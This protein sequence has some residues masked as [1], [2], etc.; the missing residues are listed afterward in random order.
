MNTFGIELDFLQVGDGERSGDAIAQR[1]GNPLTGYDV[2]I[3]DGGNKASGEELV[4]H[5]TGIYRTGTVQHVVNTHRCRSCLCQQVG[6]G[7]EGEDAEGLVRIGGVGRNACAVRGSVFNAPLEHITG[8]DHDAPVV[9]A[10]IVEVVGHGHRPEGAAA[11]LRVEI[12]DGRGHVHPAAFERSAELVI[13][14]DDFHAPIHGA[15]R[16]R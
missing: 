8:E 9:F 14:L 16:S 3:V 5:V 13:E 11:Q 12:K 1:Y 7:V 15:A 4:R 6:S 2:M 10:G